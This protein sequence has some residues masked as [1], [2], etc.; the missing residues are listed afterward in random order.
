MATVYAK[1]SGGSIKEFNAD[2]VG[3]LKTA[4]NLDGVHTSESSFEGTVEDSH[5]LSADE[6]IIFAKQVKGGC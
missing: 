1:V 4:M 6:V 5:S 3:E 2:T